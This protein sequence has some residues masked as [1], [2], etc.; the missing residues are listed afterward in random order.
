MDRFQRINELLSGAEAP[1]PGAQLDA[2]PKDGGAAHEMGDGDAR[3][4]SGGADEGP[5]TP[6]ERWIVRHKI[7]AGDT[8][9]GLAVR[10]DCSVNHIK[11]INGL[12]CDRCLGI[13][14]F[15]FIPT[16]SCPPEITRVPNLRALRRALERRDPASPLL[17]DL[18]TAGTSRGASAGL[19]G[20]D[21]RTAPMSPHAPPFEAYMGNAA[22]AAAAS[23]SGH[24]M[25]LISDEPTLVRSGGGTRQPELELIAQR[26]VAAQTE[27]ELQQLSSYLPGG[28]CSDGLRAVIGQWAGVGAAPGPG[29]GS[30]Q[31]FDDPLLP[32]APVRVGQGGPQAPPRIWSGGGASEAGFRRSRSQATLRG[33]GSKLVSAAA[34]WASGLVSGT[35]APGGVRGA[36]HSRGTGSSGSIRGGA[37]APLAAARDK[38][39]KHD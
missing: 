28:S 23:G 9:A 12:F 39:T 35:G 25:P 20:S 3:R 17:A 8:I 19:T 13:K 1:V 38:D 31:E 10:Y 24:V 6:S 26:T 27:R 32:P 34:G 5:G 4:G 36:R 2:G 37:F 33:M 7:T 29:G 15:L 30:G 16:P 14:S 22:A 21:G 18:P 11:R